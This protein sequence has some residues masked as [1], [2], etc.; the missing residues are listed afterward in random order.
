MPQHTLTQ[1]VVNFSDNLRR[2]QDFE[3]FDD[4]I[5][6]PTD[7]RFRATSAVAAQLDA[8]IQAITARAA[9]DQQRAQ[10]DP[11]AAA[12]RATAARTEIFTAVERAAADLDRVKA[13]HAADHAA[14]D[15]RR[16][17]ITSGRLVPDGQGGHRPHE[18]APVSA[19][20]AQRRQR[21]RAEWRAQPQALLEEQYLRAVADGSNPRLVTLVETAPQSLPLVRQFTRDRASELRLQH[22]PAA[23]HVTQT[24]Q[25]LELQDFAIGHAER[26]IEAFLAKATAKR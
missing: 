3:N 13:R 26:A 16:D 15:A 24:Q 22:S 19:D 6:A 25:A 23:A 5:R 11:Q 10:R 2:T 14:H 7:A 9:V 12:V 17:G 20:E 21:E 18:P 1:D 8:D 4:D